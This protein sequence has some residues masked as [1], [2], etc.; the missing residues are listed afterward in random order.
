MTA[1]KTHEQVPFSSKEKE[2][3]NKKQAPTKKEITRNTK[4]ILTKYF[5]DVL[6]FQT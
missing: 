3:K 1:L 4:L 2:N 5:T 6:Y